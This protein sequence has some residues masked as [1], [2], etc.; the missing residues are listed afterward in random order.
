MQVLWNANWGMGGGGGIA[1]IAVIGNVKPV[2]S[3]QL[4]HLTNRLR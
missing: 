1:V 3:T 4:R 2:D